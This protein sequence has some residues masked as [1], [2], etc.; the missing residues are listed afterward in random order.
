MKIF[1]KQKGFTLIELLV[2]ITIFVAFL[3]VVTNSYLSIFR[4][5]KNANDLRRAYSDLRNFIDLVNDEMRSG[6]LDYACNPDKLL[7]YQ[8]PVNSNINDFLFQNEPQKSL[9]YKTNLD[10][11]DLQRCS[12]DTNAYIGAGKNDVLRIISRDGLHSTI[13]KFDLSGDGKTGKIKILRLIKINNTWTYA[14]GYAPGSTGADT[15]GYQELLFNGFNI[16]ALAFNIFPDKNFKEQSEI[17]YQFQPF[18]TMI[19][20]VKALDGKVP[21]VMDYQT[22]ISTRSYQ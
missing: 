13:L 8:V 4:A 10:I 5:Q 16:N 9:S 2:T 14:D 11:K 20:R 3:A 19:I 21:F 6:T 22:T 7:L 18:V 15:L 1:K 12:F 17:E